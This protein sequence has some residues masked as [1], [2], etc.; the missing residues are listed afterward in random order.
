MKKAFYIFLYFALISTSKTYAA[1]VLNRIDYVKSYSTYAIENMRMYKV[2]ASITLAQG[3]LESGAGNSELAKKSNNHFGIKCGSK[4][5]GGKTYHDDDAKGECFR[6]YKSV[7][8]SYNDHSKFLT[9]NK[10][11]NSLF[12]LNIQD[13][14]SW[15]RG[16]SKAGYATSPHYSGRLIEIIEDLHLYEFDETNYVSKPIQEFISSQS[17]IMNSVNDVKII[18]ANK[19]DSYY[20]IAKVF[21]LTIRQIHKYNNTKFKKHEILKKGDLVYLEPKRFRSKKNKFIILSYNSSPLEVSKNEGVKLKSLL[22]KNHISSPN[23][24]LRKGEKI[25]LR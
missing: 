12:A 21:G 1:D 25:F 7:L 24:Q 3:I 2:P 5:K 10:R 4:W 15:A 19:G 23:E 22:R 17:T 16:L 11:Y 8:E 20:K 14:K 18:K 13:Y 9:Q 6:T